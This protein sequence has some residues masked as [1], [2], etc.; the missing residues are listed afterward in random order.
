MAL[1]EK[2][3]NIPLRNKNKNLLAYG[4]PGN[5]RMPEVIVHSETYGRSKSIG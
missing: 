5:T 3:K 1:Q 2:K 4:S